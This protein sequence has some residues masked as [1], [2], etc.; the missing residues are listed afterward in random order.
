MAD[1]PQVVN[2]P[3]RE[4]GRAD[5]PVDVSL[6]TVPIIDATLPGVL[7]PTPENTN[8]ALRARDQEQDAAGLGAERNPMPAVGFGSRHRKPDFGERG[9]VEVVDLGPSQFADFGAPAPGKHHEFGTIARAGAGSVPAAAYIRRSSS[10]LSTRLAL[11]GR[12]WNR[13]LR[14]A[15]ASARFAAPPVEDRCVARSRPSAPPRARA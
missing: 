11:R 8:S 14:G 10:S 3:G 1:M 12:L 5:R 13:E 7:P 2:N 9:V 4:R 15:T 6:E